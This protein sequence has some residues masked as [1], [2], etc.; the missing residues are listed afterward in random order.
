M[1]INYHMYGGP[2]SCRTPYRFL[3][4]NEVE[5]LEKINEFFWSSINSTNNKLG[6]INARFPLELQNSETVTKR[7]YINLDR[8]NNISK[9]LDKRAD[10][11]KN[12][13]KNDKKDEEDADKDADLKNKTDRVLGELDKQGIK[14]SGE[15]DVKVSLL[16][17]FDGSQVILFIRTIDD[18]TKQHFP[19][20]TG[21]SPVLVSTYVHEMMH[22]YFDTSY[23]VPEAEEA[24]VEYSTL[25]FLYSFDKKYGTHYCTDT[26]T[27]V[28][29]KQYSI[30]LAHYGF[31]AYLF[32]SKDAYIDWVDKYKNLWRD[33]HAHPLIAIY[34]KY[35]GGWYP[36]NN[37]ENVKQLL[38]TT[39]NR[40]SS[41]DN[42]LNLFKIDHKST[43]TDGTA[44]TYSTHIRTIQDELDKNSYGVRLLE[45]W[46]LD[47]TKVSIK[48]FD[49]YFASVSVVGTCDKS[50]CRTA[51]NSFDDFV[52]N[53]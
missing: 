16:G 42:I 34:Q 22:A 27:L 40:T 12:K 41:L 37:E 50:R 17:K 51:L 49:S 24:I 18:S 35:V 44:E 52:K 20:L 23:K 30:G 21:V 47:P 15:Y 7:I 53:I 32:E 25:C 1:A 26:L 46:I 10:E 5:E 8:L 39:L 28:K 45:D 4:P 36:F 48:E 38:W 33:L 3:N 6:D 31:G 19:S 29:E 14:N 9:V 43:I 13:K 11:R 2:D